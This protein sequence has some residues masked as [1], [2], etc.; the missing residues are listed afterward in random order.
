MTPNSQKLLITHRIDSQRQGISDTRKVS[1]ENSQVSLT[2]LAFLSTLF[3]TADGSMP[4][5]CNTSS[6][7]LAAPK[8]DD[9]DVEVDC[10]GAAWLQNG[11]RY[12]VQE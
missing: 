8:M 2:T 12:A 6:R 9:F 7:G 4:L 11:V 1:I 5:D 3:S 10:V